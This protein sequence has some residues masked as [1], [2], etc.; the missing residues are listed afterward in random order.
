MEHRLELKMLQK[1]ILTPQLQQAIKLLQLPQLELSQTLQNEMVENPFL[2]EVTDELSGDDSD[3]EEPLE[4]AASQNAETEVQVSG[5]V[6]FSVSDYFDT[7]SYDGRDLGY[8][9][10]DVTPTQTLEHYVSEGTDLYDHLDWQLRLSDST[11]EVR[12]AAEAVIGNID[13]N[14]YL[15]ATDEEIATHASC[16]MDVA[17]K[18]IGLI[19]T[20]DPIGIGARDL[21]ECLLLQLGPLNLTGTLVE[22]LIANNLDDIE[23]RK[24]QQLA[25]RYACSV[26]EIKEAIKIISE[27]EPKPGRG[28]SDSQP[29]YIKPDVYIVRADGGF[30]IILND[31]NIPNI[32]INNH[33]KKIL[34]AKEALEKN[35]KAYLEDKLRSAVWLLK[36][37]DHR[38]KTIYRVTESILEFQKNFFEQGVSKLNPLNLKDVAQELEMHESTISRATSNKYLSCSH[39]LFNFRYFFSSSLKTDTGSVSSTSVKDMIKKLVNEESQKKPLSDQ[40]ISEMLKEFNIKV[41]RRTVAKYREEMNIPPQSIRKQID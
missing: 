19:Q 31:D 40:K 41:A 13:E 23:K 17:R 1:L 14:G 39:G 15:Q 3:S 10:P 38:N 34:Q 24:F 18:A 9:S 28:F 7:R 26:E 5:E 36:S 25:T 30:Q 16:P 21:K 4:S 6:D 32:R 11:P 33:Y 8:F 27:L 37:L 12:E 22:N 2:E 20:F 35:D 29:I